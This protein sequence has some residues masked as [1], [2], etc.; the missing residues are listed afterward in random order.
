M[1]HC[2]ICLE[3]LEHNVM[4]T[5]CNHKFHSHCINRWL[6]NNYT[7]ALCRCPIRDE[8]DEVDIDE[9]SEEDSEDE[10]IDEDYLPEPIPINV[11]VNIN[12]SNKTFIIIILLLIKFNI[13]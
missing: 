6:E 2:S 5:I 10:G 11:N 3:D 8:V 12:I 9:D 7:C 4:E 1:E 13:F